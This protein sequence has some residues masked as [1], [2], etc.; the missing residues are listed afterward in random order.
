MPVVRQTLEHNPAAAVMSLLASHAEGQIFLAE[1][2]VWLDKYGQRGY[3][4][5]GLG[6]ESWLDDPAPVIH[7]LQE[8]LSLPDQDVAVEIQAQ[9]AGRAEQIAQARRRLQSQ[10]ATSS[11]E[12]LTR[13]DR[14]LQA[15][16]CGEFLLTEHNFWIDQQAMY[17]LRL[18]FLEVGRRSA[19]MGL[20]DQPEDIFYLTLDEV[21]A[22]TQPGSAFSRQA[23]VEKRKAEMARSCTLTP[24]DALGTMPWLAPPDEPFARAF[25]RLLGASLIPTAQSPYSTSPVMRGQA[26]SPGK[27]R[28]KARVIR[29]LEEAERLQAGE[30]LVTRATMPSWTPLLAMAGGVV[31]DVGGILSHAAIIAR[32]YG[33]PAV[34]ATRVGSE[35]IEDGQLVEVDGG[36]GV[37]T[38]LGEDMS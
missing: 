20:L 13:F 31:T 34:V 22:S 14:Q 17:R 2:R 6:M 8:S 33:I 3:G 37:V 25:S 27:V 21:L 10:P 19:A 23:L 11:P 4:V 12:A 30:I 28:A 38:V 16:Q 32:E 7:T 35:V 9:A 29:S 18:V 26:A 24:P 5:D 15:A 36:G 1:L